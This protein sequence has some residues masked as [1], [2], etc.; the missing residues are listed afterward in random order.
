MKR[1]LTTQELQVLLG[2]SI[3]RVRL[4]QNID[5]A[6]VARRA[7]ISRSALQKLETGAGSSVK[8]LV[9]VLRTLGREDWIESLAPQV[10]INPLDLV[11]A[12]SPRQRATGNRRKSVT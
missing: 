1:L 5:L 9:A 6:T 8:T 7:G 3:R 12:G 11:G 10:T 2:D 4:Q